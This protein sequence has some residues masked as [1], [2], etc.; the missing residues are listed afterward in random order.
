MHMVIDLQKKYAILLF[1]S[2]LYNNSIVAAQKNIDFVF[3]SDNC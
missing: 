3:D 2:R 1:V